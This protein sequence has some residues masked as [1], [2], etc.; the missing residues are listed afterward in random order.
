MCVDSLDL[1]TCIQDYPMVTAI[2]FSC[3]RS[4]YWKF[5]S[6][7]LTVS[8]FLLEDDKDIS[9]SIYFENLSEGNKLLFDKLD[10]LIH[11]DLTHVDCP[12]YCLS[13]TYSRLKN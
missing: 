2:P 6:C 4:L 1:V 5:F 10:D 7:S 3:S 13:Y 11:D 12:S 8:S 9:G